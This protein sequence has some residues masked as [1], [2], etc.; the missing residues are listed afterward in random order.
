MNY[1]IANTSSSLS[2]Y[3]FPP[4]SLFPSCHCFNDN[5]LH[6]RRCSA[7]ELLNVSIF[8]VASSCTGR[9]WKRRQALGRL[10]RQCNLYFHLCQRHRVDL[11]ECT[12]EHFYDCS[13]LR[14]IDIRI[15]NRCDNYV[16]CSSITERDDL[17]L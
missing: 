15:K 12:R 1:W 8:N 16:L 5:F 4:L 10:L 17:G 14:L 9:R 6:S 7:D 3:T 13:L 11:S 2:S